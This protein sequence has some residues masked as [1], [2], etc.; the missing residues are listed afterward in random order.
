VHCVKDLIRERT[1]PR[2]SPRTLE[3]FC[4]IIV[5]IFFVIVEG[6]IIGEIVKKVERVVEVIGVVIII[7]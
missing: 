5:V 7:R 2:H 4:V 3:F 6:F 1:M